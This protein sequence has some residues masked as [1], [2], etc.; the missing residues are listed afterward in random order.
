MTTPLTS[1]RGMFWRVVRRLLLAH[2]A[3]LVVILLALGAGAVVTAALLNLQVDAKRRI[4]SE[5]RAFGANILITPRNVISTGPDAGNLNLSIYER[6]PKKNGINLVTKAL[7]SYGIA[8]VAPWKTETQAA[9]PGLATP[10]V[11]VEYEYYG[12]DLS[13][14]FPAVVIAQPPNRHVAL[15]T[16]DCQIGEQLARRLG[17]RIL[18]FLELRADD[19]TAICYVTRISR[20]GGP[21][22]SQVFVESNFATDLLKQQKTRRFIALN[23]PGNPASVAQY[24]S[25]LQAV[26]PDAD[27]RPIRQ[28]TEAQAKIYGRISGLL[29]FTVALVLV[30]T[31]LCVM[32]AMTNVAM[33]RKNDVGLMK[34]IGGTSRRVLR[35]FL[36][37]AALLGFAGG[38]IG[39]AIGIVLSIYLGKA[40]FGIAAR[41]RLIVYPVSV[42]LT[43]LIA[44]LS[45]FPLRM[46]AS[47]RPASV[48]RGEA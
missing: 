43:M 11:V 38:L 31:G 28:F 20:F 13:D 24:I 23:V 27:V 30:L 19:S 36:A 6:I 7:L 45:A 21:E 40:V 4:N 16:P 14:I 46:L 44:I 8:T 29:N 1:N 48:F 9:D 35:L 12:S 17:M 5:F 47:V 39:A 15:G 2:R 3:R 18:Q 32:A 22:D 25:N 26:V 37:E 33:E 10:A 34:A 42:F 41:P